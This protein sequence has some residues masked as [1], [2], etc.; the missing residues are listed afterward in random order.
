MWTSTVH[1]ISSKK[2]SNSTKVTHLDEAGFSSILKVFRE[3]KSLC[4]TQRLSKILTGKWEEI[5]WCRTL[6]PKTINS[7]F[8]GLS[9]FQG[10][11]IHHCT[12]WR[13][14]FSLVRAA[15]KFKWEIWY[16]SHRNEIFYQYGGWWF[17]LVELYK[18]RTT[19]E[20]AQNLR[21]LHGW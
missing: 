8:S 6:E 7:V 3:G 21:E 1:L 16:R 20:P 4:Q 10:W 19:V 5:F 15:K 17:C 9:F 14:V 12:S 18:V 13:Q 2:L 11:A